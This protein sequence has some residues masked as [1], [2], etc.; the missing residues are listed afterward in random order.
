MLNQILPEHLHTAIN[1]DHGLLEGASAREVRLSD[2]RGYFT[3]EQAWETA[4]AAGDPVIYTVAGV[5]PATGDGQLH[6]GLGKLM[7]GRIG[8]E[9]YLTKGHFHTFRAAAEIYVGL[10]GEGL[11]VLEEEGSGI[12]KTV[13]LRK[14]SIVYVPGHTAHR[15]VNTGDI[16]LSYLGIYDAKAGHDYGVIAER[17][18]LQIVV[19]EDGRPVLVDRAAYRPFDQ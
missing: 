8:R 4:I 14:N 2:L 10:E 17:N 6:Y 16:P 7:P 5:E 9:Y 12:T 11:M 15:T 18:F 1:P 13:P 3:D 19:E